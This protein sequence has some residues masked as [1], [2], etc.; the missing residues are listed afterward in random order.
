MNWT[1]PLVCDWILRIF[2]VSFSE[3]GTRDLL[4]LLGFSYIKTTYTL[5]KA[6]AAKQTAFLEAF[7]H[8]KKTNQ[9]TN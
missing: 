1:A 8:V 2:D 7:E 9:R 4:Y 5:Q 3:R 6:D